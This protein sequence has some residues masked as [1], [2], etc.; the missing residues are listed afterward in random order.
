MIYPLKFISI[1]KN[2][3]WGGRNIEKKFNRHIPEG[4]V[5]E[6]WEVCCRK[7]GI[8]VVSNGTYKG[9][10]LYDLIKTYKEEL[11]GSEVYSSFS[12]TFPLILKIIDAND[13]LS[14]QVHPGDNYQ[15]LENGESRKTEMWYII[16]AKPNA[17][18]VYG[19]KEGITKDEFADAVKNKDIKHTLNFVPVKKGDSFF[20]P[21]GTVHAILDGILIAEIQQNSNTTYRVYDWDR[22]DDKGHFR[23]LH[24]NKALNAI[25]F[26]NGEGRRK[27][28]KPA[29]VC[30]YN[31]Y[32]SKELVKSKY[33]TVEEIDV[34]STYN[35]A[36]D[37]TRF[38]IYM[39]L[40]G[41]GTVSYS[42]GEE[43]INPGDTILIPAT[44]GKYEL[45]GN[46]KALKMYV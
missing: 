32:S 22:V 13:K 6:S 19:L 44:L 15:G 9:R 20:I 4:K 18:I 3:I 17:Q 25:S 45:N 26:D 16:D 35:N 11:L 23:E 36:T 39:N 10:D 1:Y 30:E 29:K 24:I 38:F 5:A 8:S 21:G 7:E 12:D 34:K 33:F 42:G 43:E 37:G 27:P 28:E 14:V 2:I 41:K 40:E 46:I 31:N